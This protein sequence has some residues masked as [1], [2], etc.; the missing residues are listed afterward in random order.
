MIGGVAIPNPDHHPRMRT[1]MPVAV[2]PVEEEDGLE[3]LSLGSTSG[4]ISVW[5]SSPGRA[6]I[7]TADIDSLGWRVFLTARLP[8]VND[9]ACM[10]SLVI[11][12]IPA[13]AAEE[14]E[15]RVG[16]SIHAIIAT[17]HRHR[18]RTSCFCPG[19]YCCF[20]VVVLR[21]W[22]RDDKPLSTRWQISSSHIFSLFIIIIET[23]QLQAS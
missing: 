12:L 19:C 9:R 23:R 15:R 21:P 22:W 16:L 2:I 17:L 3:S 5:A 20:F 14:R 8:L 4:F 7:S 13:G 18:D 10:L 1:L 11:L 6:F